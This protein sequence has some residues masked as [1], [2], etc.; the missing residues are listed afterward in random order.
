MPSHKTVKNILTG[1]DF[2]VGLF[3]LC[4]SNLQNTESDKQ[5]CHARRGEV[6]C[7]LISADEFEITLGSYQRFTPNVGE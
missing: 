3:E 1:T 4:F 7:A 6:Q 2:K 5:E